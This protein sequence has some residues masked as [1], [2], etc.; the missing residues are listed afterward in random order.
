LDG[1]YRIETRDGKVITTDRAVVAD[2]LIII[3]AVLI[4]GK[5]RAVK[6]F[7]IARSDVVAI[8]RTETNYVL[9]IGVCAG[10]AAIATLVAFVIHNLGPIGQ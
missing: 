10:I 9:L 5:R 7:G 2:S 3:D 4:D 1:V 6:Q 8:S